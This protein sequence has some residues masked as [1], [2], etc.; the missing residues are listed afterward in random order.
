MSIDINIHPAVNH[1]QQPASADFAGGTLYC[2]CAA[3]KVEI[4]V[5]GQSAYN[6]SCL[7]PRWPRQSPAC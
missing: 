1:G 4:A 3:D 2:G 5:G 7:S 6:H